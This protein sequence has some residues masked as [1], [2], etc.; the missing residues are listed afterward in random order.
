M[1]SKATSKSA[2]TAKA[3]GQTALGNNGSAYGPTALPSLQYDGN[4]S[5]MRKSPEGKDNDSLRYEENKPPKDTLQKYHDLSNIVAGGNGDAITTIN[6]A[7]TTANT[8][9]RDVSNANHQKIGNDISTE[10]FSA[11]N[12]NGKIN[13]QVTVLVGEF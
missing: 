9:Y 4:N 3:S 6:N 5:T 13:V 11:S 1:S 10:I 7:T 2:T 12:D 8:K